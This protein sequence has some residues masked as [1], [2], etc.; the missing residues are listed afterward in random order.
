MSLFWYIIGMTRIKIDPDEEIIIQGKD[1]RYM[2]DGLKQLFSDFD[3]LGIEKKKN[4]GIAHK[5]TVHMAATIIGVI[6]MMPRRAR[7]DTMKLF[8]ET[9]GIKLDGLEGFFH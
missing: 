7:K 9:T 4:K 6:R 8:E 2:M 1:L 5:A 3:A